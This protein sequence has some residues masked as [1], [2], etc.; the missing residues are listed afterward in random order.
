MN[1]EHSGRYPQPDLIAPGLT[2]DLFERLRHERGIKFA[3]VDLDNTLADALPNSTGGHD[4]DED[5]VHALREARSKG[6]LIDYSLL[7]NIQIPLPRLKRRVSDFAQ[8]LDTKHFHAATFGHAKPDPRAFRIVLEL[9]E[10]NA[11][12]T[13]VIGDQLDTDI[14]GAHSIGAYSILRYPHFG[15]DAFYKEGKRRKQQ[16][17]VASFKR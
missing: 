13:V 3:I 7:S 2:V 1:S 6:F 5:S 9:M 12:E 8:L 10:A 11:R 14:A 15:R 16:T 17:I 4:I